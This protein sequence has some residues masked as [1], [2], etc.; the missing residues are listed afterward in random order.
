MPYRRYL[1]PLAIVFVLGLT[2]CGE[3]ARQKDQHAAQ[4]SAHATRELHQASA[5]AAISEVEERIASIE[6]SDAQTRL[7]ALKLGRPAPRLHLREI[8]ALHARV[9]KIRHEAGGAP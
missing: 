8:L 4:E 3:T 5:A 7:A 6:Y 9:R 1:R 2:G